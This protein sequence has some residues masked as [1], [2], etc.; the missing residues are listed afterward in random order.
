[1]KKI[2]IFLGVIVV[3][4]LAVGF[5]MTR[6]PN[7]I[8]EIKIGAILPLTGD[9]ATYG[10]ALK[11]GVDLALEEVNAGGGIGNKKVV[12]VYED[13]QE[14]PK[15][16]V[17]AINKLISVDKVRVVIGDMFSSVTLA[18][19]PIAQKSKVV[20]VSPTASAEA[21]PNTGDYIFSIYPSDAYDGKFLADFVFEKL[22]KRNAATL[23]VQA[24]AMIT[25]KDSFRKVFEGLGGKITF[26]EGYAP[27]TDDYRSLLSKAKSS[28]PDVIFIP[29]YLEDIVKLTKQARELGI[30]SQFITISTAYDSKL[31]ELGKNTVDGLLL[32]A[33]FFETATNQQEVISFKEAFRKKF[34][35]EPNVWA[36]YGYDVLKI[37]ILAFKNSTKNHTEVKNEL[38]RI[39]NYPGVTGET[40]FLPNRSV[41]KILKIM[42][43]SKGKFTEYPR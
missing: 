42:M 37:V 10:T 36:A 18:I 26:E 39:K 30:K 38:L 11:K 4:V 12:V 32:S 24:D 9:A 34:N 41:E 25:C 3:I 27:K 6:I 23:F 43:A 1:M 31:F 16:A 17:S 33:P 5:G 7:H 13:S 19:A 29:G 35:E 8:K 21:V 2:G 15:S 40:S 22:Q 14:D 20:L 28:N